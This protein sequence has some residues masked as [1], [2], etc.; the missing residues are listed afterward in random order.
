MFWDTRETREFSTV[1]T[2][3]RKAISCKQPVISL[4]YYYYYFYY[5]FEHIHTSVFSL[6]KVLRHLNTGVS[7]SNSH[8]AKIKSRTKS[9]TKLYIYIEKLMA[10]VHVLLCRIF[11]YENKL[12]FCV[13]T[14]SGTTEA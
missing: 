6:V 11:P 5:Y 1:T 7:N 3:E 10:I 12:W 4:M 9:R 14:K 13:N 2:C 8:W